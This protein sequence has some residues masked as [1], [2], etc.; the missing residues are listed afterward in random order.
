MNRKLSKKEI[1]ILLFLI[2]TVFLKYIYEPFI[3]SISNNVRAIVDSAL[4][5]IWFIVGITLLSFCF[6]NL[7]SAIAIKIKTK[8]LKKESSEYLNKMQEYYIKFNN[9]KYFGKI[10]GFIYLL[11][12]SM[13][14][15]GLLF[16]SYNL[17][18][19]F[20]DLLRMKKMDSNS[21]EYKETNDYYMYHLDEMT[22]FNLIATI[23]FFY[24]RYEEL[25][26]GNFIPGFICIVVQILLYLILIKRK[27]FKGSNA[28][29]KYVICILYMIF[30][31]C[32]LLFIFNIS[33]YLTNIGILSISK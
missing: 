7:F 15:M 18:L 17:I 9:A 27:V 8:G 26:Y 6:S 33:I 12:N 28:K 4:L 20:I 19:S 14:L 25:S 2:F 24:L 11:Y 3:N 21:K 29:K 31:L 22:F 10:F 5:F 23:A 32:F 30:F 16:T 1:V 13:F